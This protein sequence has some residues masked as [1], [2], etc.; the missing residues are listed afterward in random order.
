MRLT[1]LSTD[2]QV[3]CLRCEGQITL[4]H[5]KPGV[6][7]LTQVAGNDVYEQRVLIDLEGTS[8]IDSI[9]V[10]WLM[11]CH[12]RFMSGGGRMVLYSI[13][14]RVR[15]TLDLLKL[16]RVMALADNEA[17]ARQMALQAEQ[18]E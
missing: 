13:P 8:Y 10:G 3:V 7:H 16:H 5:I 1:H 6:D 2:E 15:Q 9:G 11:A 14:P 12:K 17:A 18:E 4:A